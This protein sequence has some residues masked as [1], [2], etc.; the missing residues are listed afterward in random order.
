LV[1]IVLTIFS[2]EVA[3]YKVNEGQVQMV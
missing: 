2:F 3:S 1:C